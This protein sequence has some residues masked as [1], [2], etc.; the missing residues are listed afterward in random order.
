MCVKLWP[1]INTVIDW[2]SPFMVCD[3]PIYSP[4]YIGYELIPQLI[5]NQLGFWTLLIWNHERFLTYT[6]S[7]FR[8]C[9]CSDKSIKTEQIQR[10]GSENR[11]VY[12]QYHPVSFLDDRVPAETGVGYVRDPPVYLHPGDKVGSFWN[13]GPGGA[14]NAVLLS[15]P[16]RWREEF[17]V[18]QGQ[19]STLVMMLLWRHC[20]SQT[21]E[22]SG[23]SLASWIIHP[24][25]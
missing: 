2:G 9:D 17:V 22:E 14:S 4:P 21:T 25:I 19:G 20:L 18:C 10:H 23:T 1:I 5:I 8:D 7:N 11:V 16:S 6:S 24:V 12:F 13:S 15:L 3:I